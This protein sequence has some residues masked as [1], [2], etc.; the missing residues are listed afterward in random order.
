MKHQD[1]TFRDETVD[2][3]GVEFSN[4]TFER[5][6]VRYSGGALPVLAGCRFGGCQFVF[7]RE[8]ENTLNFIRALYHSGMPEVVESTFADLRAN[9]PNWN[10]I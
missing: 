10:P 1:K 5:C 6:R 9:A 8:A 4:C 3:D 2:V 7:A